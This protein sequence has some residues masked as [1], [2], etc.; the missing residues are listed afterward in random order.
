MST[1]AIKSFK[2]KHYFLSN[3]FPCFVE[4]E[5]LTYPSAECAYQ[6]AK[7][8]DP[9]VRYYFTGLPNS[10]EARRW[11]NQIELR[12]DWEE[13]RFSVMN[14]IL[15][16]KFKHDYLKEMLL[17]TGDAHL[18]EGNMHNDTYW[19]TVK[20]KGENNLGNILMAIRKEICD[21]ANDN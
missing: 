14:D 8:L 6:A 11:G 12:P 3:F 21:E 17:S 16:S 5:G 19:G 18:E 9:A 15:H 1:K 4:Y 2:N 13:V 10:M 7:S 20:G